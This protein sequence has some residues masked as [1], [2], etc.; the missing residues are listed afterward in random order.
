MSAPMHAHDAEC[1]IGADDCCTTCGVYH[2]DACDFCGGKGFHV[3]TCD[4]GPPVVAVRPANQNALEGQAFRP[5]S[6]RW[7]GA[8]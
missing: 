7:A 2:G 3:G 5:T 4:G 8:K 6:R 1:T